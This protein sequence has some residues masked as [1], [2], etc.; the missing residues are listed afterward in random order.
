MHKVW[1][2]TGASRGLGTEIARAALEAGDDVVATARDSTSI[3]KA[4]GVSEHLAAV[5][6]DVTKHGAPEEAVRAAIARFGHIDVLVNNAGYGLMGAL[7]ECTEEEVKRQFD[8]NFVGLLAVLR[9]TLPI[10]RA[11]RS[12]HIFNLSSVAGFRGDAGASSYCASKFAVEGLSESLAGEMAPLGIKVTIVEPGYFRTDFLSAGSSRFA[13]RTIDDYDSTAGQVRRAMKQY[14]GKQA[15]DPRKLARALV[16]LSNSPQPPLRFTAGADA[17][18]W[19]EE[20][21]SLKRAELERWRSLSASL[22]F[23]A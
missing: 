4:L 16:T 15:N 3:E 10:L 8:T 12:G 18:Q 17:V 22:A 20:N 5:S 7:E 19:F 6:L 9:A 21:L 14:D 1:F 11:Q 13:S 2:I 23:D